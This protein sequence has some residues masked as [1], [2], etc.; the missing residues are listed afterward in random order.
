[1]RVEPNGD[2]FHRSEAG[3]IYDLYNACNGVFRD[4]LLDLRMLEEYSPA[5]AEE[6]NVPRLREVWAHAASGCYQCENIINALNNLR[7]AAK[8]A[9]AS[10]V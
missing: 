5:E 6:L 7:G 8:T 1:M 10:S 9:C 4:G 3:D 2:D